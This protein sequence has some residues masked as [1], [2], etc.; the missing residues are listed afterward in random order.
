MLIVVVAHQKRPQSEEDVYLQAASL[1]YPIGSR[2]ASP[3]LATMAANSMAAAAAA[4]RFVPSM[5]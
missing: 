4:A 1:T 2:E 3:T 5:V